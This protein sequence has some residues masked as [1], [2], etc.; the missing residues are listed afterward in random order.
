MQELAVFV[1]AESTMKSSLHTKQD[2]CAIK[3]CDVLP[4]DILFVLDDRICNAAGTTYNNYDIL[5]TS[6]LCHCQVHTSSPH[7]H[8]LWLDVRIRAIM[9]HDYFAV[10]SLV[11]TNLTLISRLPVQ[12]LTQA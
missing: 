5:A 1:D 8:V 11:G 10:D 12:K 3:P 7:I 9:K 6:A 4:G 2:A